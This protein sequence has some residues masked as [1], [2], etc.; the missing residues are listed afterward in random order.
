MSEHITFPSFIVLKLRGKNAEASLFLVWQKIGKVDQSVFKDL[1]KLNK[2]SIQLYG[3]NSADFD[4]K[5][6]LERSNELLSFTENL[7]ENK[8]YNLY[9]DV[10]KTNND[11]IIYSKR[12][13]DILGAADFT[14]LPSDIQ[15]A[16]AYA[17][18]YNQWRNNLSTY[19]PNSVINPNMG[20]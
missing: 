4:M 14:K 1:A 16:A 11:K 9:I 12:I 7:A 20:R 8:I 5:L 2:E 15:T 6:R 18:N 19:R 13:A 10:N 17:F 3:A